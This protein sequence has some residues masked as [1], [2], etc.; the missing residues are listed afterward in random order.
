MGLLSW[1]LLGAI[2]G[3]IAHSL[4]GKGNAGCLTNIIVGVLGSFIGGLVVN[5]MTLG[6]ISPDT[7][8]GFNIFSLLVSVFGA[9]IFLAILSA[10]RK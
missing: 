3:W 10:V 2:A 5:F 7:F 1:I 4:T 9:V 6:V 8:T